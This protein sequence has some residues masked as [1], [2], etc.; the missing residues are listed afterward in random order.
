MAEAIT[1]ARDGDG[2]SLIEAVTYRLSDHTTADDARRYRSDAEVS[3]HWKDEPIARLRAHLVARGAWG[4]ETELELAASCRANIETAVTAYLSAIPAA[5]TGMIDYVHA[6]LPPAFADQ[7]ATV[8]R[9]TE[10]RHG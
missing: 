8:E 4:K 2:P 6:H 10:D 1:R 5:A 9:A 7:R 3:T